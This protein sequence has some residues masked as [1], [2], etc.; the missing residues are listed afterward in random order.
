MVTVLRHS[1]FSMKTSKKKPP[2]HVSVAA[3]LGSFQLKAFSEPQRGDDQGW[4]NR[5]V[6]GRR[7]HNPG[8]PT[9]P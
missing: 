4:S 5:C 9:A 2:A 3:L 1:Q 6:I 7:P 8:R